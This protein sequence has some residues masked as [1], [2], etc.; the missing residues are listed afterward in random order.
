MLNSEP[1]LK[2]KEDLKTPLSID[3]NGI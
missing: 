3:Y 2:G 1:G